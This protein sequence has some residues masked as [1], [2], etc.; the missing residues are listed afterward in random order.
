MGK[1][2]PCYA[3]C[4]IHVSQVISDN[5]SSGPLAAQGPFQ[6]TSHCQSLPTSHPGLKVMSYKYTMARLCF[7]K[8][9]Y[10]NHS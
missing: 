3:G 7:E 1:M 4:D 6:I 2:V 9:N 8:I 5:L 10:H